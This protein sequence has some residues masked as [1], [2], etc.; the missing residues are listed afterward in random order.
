MQVSQ[1]SNHLV[2]ALRR[3]GC[4]IFWQAGRDPA[5]LDVRRLQLDL[6]KDDVQREINQ[7][8]KVYMQALD[9]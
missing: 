4:A 7:N 2:R 9:T 8:I 6:A 3:E 5:V 1:R